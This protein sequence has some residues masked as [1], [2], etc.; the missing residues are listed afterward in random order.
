MKREKNINEQLLEQ[1]MEMTHIDFEA[2][3]KEI[4]NVL[5]E[6]G[7][8]LDYKTLNET[9][10]DKFEGVRLRLKTMKEKGIVDFEG[11]IPSFNSKIKLIK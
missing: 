5:K 7:G 1:L 6:H 9:L 2:E 4:V 3:Y 8:V 10:A 11:I